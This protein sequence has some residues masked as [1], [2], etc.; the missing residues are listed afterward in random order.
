M[1]DRATIFH[2][3]DCCELKPV[4]I[5]LT[6]MMMAIAECYESGV[7]E[8]Q[9]HGLSVVDVVRFGEIRHKHNPGMAQS[10][11]ANGW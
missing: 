2:V 6:G 1:V 7:Y 11:Y 8:I 4:F 3:N 10:I 9:E 5:N